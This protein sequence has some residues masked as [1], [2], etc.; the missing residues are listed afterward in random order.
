MY[1][2]IKY[3]TNIYGQELSD[4]D[5]IELYRPN[6]LNYLPPVLQEIKEF[7]VWNDI[8]GYELALLNWESNDVLK[9]CFIDT[10]TWGL[11]LW[12]EEYGVKT[13]LSKSYEDRRKFI[14]A[15]KRGHGTVTKKLIEETA[16]AFSCGEV[17]IIEHPRIYSFT[18][19]FIGVK[20][21]P[22]NL[23]G[24]KDM[25]DAIKPA[26]LSYDFKYTYTI[27]GFLKEKSFTWNNGKSKVWNDLKVYEGE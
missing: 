19:Q 13:D 20:G 11:T 9:Q 8:V 5:E 24:F 23:A 3:G 14:K 7:K 15:K 4:T 17:E 10:A 12:E 16:E 6:L 18:V 22:R 27:W 21:I 1:G 26:H 2:S 25:L